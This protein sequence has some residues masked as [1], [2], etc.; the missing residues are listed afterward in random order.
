MK[1]RFWKEFFKSIK[2]KGSNNS[3]KIC[4]KCKKES[5]FRTNSGNWTNTE[6]YVC[7]ECDYKGAFYI[8]VDPEENGNNFIDLEKIKEIYPEDID[9]ETEIEINER[10]IQ[11]I[12]IKETKKS[13][14][15]NK[16]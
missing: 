6:Y 15:K 16:D 5:I 4:P 8:E 2:K 1:F 14:E 9:P 13:V 11:N 3:I 7:N 10:N 12:L